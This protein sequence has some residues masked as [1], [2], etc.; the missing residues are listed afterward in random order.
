MPVLIECLLRCGFCQLTKKSTIPVGYTY[1]DGNFQIL[2]SVISGEGWRWRQVEDAV[3]RL[4][5]VYCSDRCEDSA[6]KA[7]LK[8][9]P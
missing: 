7:S 2:S 6:A 9:T 1:A 3:G 5:E 4:L 8:E